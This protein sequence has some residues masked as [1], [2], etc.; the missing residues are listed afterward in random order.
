M[1]T[2]EDLDKSGVFLTLKSLIEKV[3]AKKT[4]KEQSDN[5]RV[6]FSRD[7]DMDI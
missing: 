5:P 6:E 3:L 7:E 4:E 1:N 2:E